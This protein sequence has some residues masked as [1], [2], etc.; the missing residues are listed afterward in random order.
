[1]TVYV[2]SVYKVIMFVSH[3]VKGNSTW[4]AP[5]CPLCNAHVTLRKQLYV[6]CQAVIYIAVGQRF[7]NCVPCNSP[8]HCNRGHKYT[9]N[10]V[11]QLQSKEFMQELETRNTMLQRDFR[12]RWLKGL[13]RFPTSRISKR[14]HEFKPKDRV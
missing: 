2:F 7:P 14:T 13:E 12:K 6:Y 1:M 9:R 11:T 4:S 3:R 10:L 5:L 8:V